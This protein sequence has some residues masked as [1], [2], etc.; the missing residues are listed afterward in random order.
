MNCGAVRFDARWG[1]EEWV[2]A[3][4]L[5]EAPQPPI[6]TANNRVSVYHSWIRRD[7][8]RFRS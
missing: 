2:E 6:C 1:N 7:H 8:A 5:T 4:A 3:N